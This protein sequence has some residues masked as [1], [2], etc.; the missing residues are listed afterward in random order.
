MA[1]PANSPLEWITLNIATCVTAVIA[2]FNGELLLEIV[3][4]MSILALMFFNFWRGMN[5][6]EDWK[7]KRRKAK[8]EDQKA[9]HQPNESDQT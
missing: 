9:Q 7:A 4:G 2:W 3:A 5:Q 1:A 6:F 8:N